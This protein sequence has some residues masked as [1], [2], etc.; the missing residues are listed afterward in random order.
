VIYLTGT[1]FEKDRRRHFVMEITM[2]TAYMFDSEGPFAIED[3]ALV[4]RAL[5]A[6]GIR[7]FEIV[8]K[9]P[10][11]RVEPIR[12]YSETAPRREQVSELVTTLSLFPLSG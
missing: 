4:Q 10:L 3:S 1:A 2:S 8:P 12:V 6:R 5:E 7:R 11:E 9:T